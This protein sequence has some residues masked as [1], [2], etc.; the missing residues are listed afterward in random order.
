MGRDASGSAVLRGALP[1]GVAVRATDTPLDLEAARSSLLGEE[2]AAVAGAAPTRVRE[3]ATGRA[4]ARGALAD[5][6][7][8]PGPVPVG[9]DRAPRW[10]PGFVGSITHCAGFWAAAV[11]STAVLSRLGVDAEVHAPLEPDVADLVIAPGER[12]RVAGLPPGWAVAWDT[13]LFSA[14]EA[15]FK[16]TF[17][18]DRVWREAADVA[19]DLR[20]DGSFAATSRTPEALPPLIG[21]WRVTSTLVV[22]AAYSRPAG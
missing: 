9:P 1:A 16:A 7:V 4:C 20:P 13:V 14:K 5:L 3:F 2:A 8:T 15:V 22:T 11:A 10:P 18:A 21:R 6:G 19:V 17:P 12:E